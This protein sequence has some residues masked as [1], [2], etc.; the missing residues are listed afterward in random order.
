[1]VLETVG[2]SVMFGGVEEW[3]GKGAGG[4]DKGRCPWCKRNLAVDPCGNGR[5]W[6]GVEGE[7]QQVRTENEPDW[8]GR[9]PQEKGEN[10]KTMAAVED[11]LEKS[12]EGSF[13]SRLSFCR[14][15]RRRSAAGSRMMRL[16]LI[17]TRV[18]IYYTGMDS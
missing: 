6:R 12:E 11:G 7:R 18:A 8:I 4:L 2:L 17:T 15:S 14:L 3:R 16:C 13:V 10:C 5:L 9:N 1:M